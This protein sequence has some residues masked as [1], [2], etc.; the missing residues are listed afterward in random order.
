MKPIATLK[1]PLQSVDIKSKHTAKASVERADVCAVPAAGVVG[2]SAVC[3]CLAEAL[4][5]KF[6]A[7]SLN[8]IKRNYQGYLTQI[9]KF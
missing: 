4:L 7:D 9:K 6:G 1:K 8:E 2:E 3:F 5:E